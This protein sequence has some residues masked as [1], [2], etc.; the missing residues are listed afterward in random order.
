MENFKNSSK[1]L[2]AVLIAPFFAKDTKESY[3]CRKFRQPIIMDRYLFNGKTEGYASVILYITAFA[4]SFIGWMAPVPVILLT[5]CCLVLHYSKFKLQEKREINLTAALMLSFFL[6]TLIADLINGT[7]LSSINRM[8]FQIRLPLLLLSL[9][10]LFKHRHF[11]AY[12]ALKFHAWGSYATVAVVLLTFFWEIAFDFD[13]VEL[14]LFHIRQCLAAVFVA[15]SHRTYINFN[16]LIALI[17]VVQWYDRRPTIK[18]LGTLLTTSLLTGVFIFISEARTSLISYACLVGILTFVQLRKRLKPQQMFLLTIVC[19]V[20]FIGVLGL[21][22]RIANT[23]YSLTKG[24]VAL[25]SL[26]PRF[27]IWSCAYEI[28]SNGIPFLGLGGDQLQP[29]L[30][31]CYAATHF[32]Y[33]EFCGLG[34]HNQYIEVLLE[35]GIIGLLLFVVLLSSTLFKKGE[36]RKYQFLLFAILSINFLFE[37]MI[38]RSI[39]AYNIAFLLVLLTNGSEEEK[40]ENISGSQPRF[41]LMA[42]MAIICLGFIRSNKSKYF[43]PFQKHFAV[44]EALPGE[45]P[46]EIKGQH[47]LR[48]DSTTPTENWGEVAFMNYYFDEFKMKEADT[49]R[50]ELY[51][52][53]DEAFDGSLV[54]IKLDERNTHLFESYYDLAQKGRWQKLS[55]EETGLKGNV[56]CS[57]SIDRTPSKDF[58]G[59]NGYVLFCQPR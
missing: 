22:T 50:F 8:E 6:F 20:A 25:I 28:A 23:F 55:L 47:A 52:Y 27:Q 30:Q 16:L 18:R 2:L 24:D 34:V 59:M 36:G 31:E 40:D 54:R 53:V 11:D 19:I 44:V 43:V 48:I 12:N 4:V 1:N 32:K 38:S 42:M 46:H 10:F 17:F 45:V 13:N 21:N 57:I 41:V 26:D 3:L 14:N 56:T 35:Y 5:L 58:S 15:T 51:V 49:A 9:A 29:L 33:G 39:G 37:T 7:P